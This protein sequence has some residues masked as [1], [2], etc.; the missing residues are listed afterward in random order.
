[1]DK[2]DIHLNLS[3]Q[4]AGYLIASVIEFHHTLCAACQYD[5]LRDELQQKIAVVKSI[6]LELER[7][8][9]IA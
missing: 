7:Q 2:I 6:W 5:H 3:E 9:G 4:E 8:T 1:M